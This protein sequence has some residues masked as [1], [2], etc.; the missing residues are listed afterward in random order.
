MADKVYHILGLL[1]DGEQAASAIEALRRTPWNLD[2]VHGP[3]P[4]HRIL[5][6]LRL[7]KSRVGYFTLA[8]GIFGFL[9]G[10]A[11]SIYTATR[12]NFIISGKPVVA[13]IPFLIIGFEFTILFSVLGNIVGFLTQ[14]RLPDFEGLKSHDPRCT[15]DH[16]GIVATCAEGEQEGLMAFFKE[17]GAESKL[18]EEPLETTFP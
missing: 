18:L 17:Q 9:L 3:I 4:E 12:W 6:V 2:R 16:F 8:G 1:R 13:L 10:F 5:E 11:L 15:H 14:T 7:K